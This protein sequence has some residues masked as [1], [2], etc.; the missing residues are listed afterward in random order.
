MVFHVGCAFSLG[1]RRWTG[2]CCVVN[3]NLAIDDHIACYLQLMMLS[4][5]AWQPHGTTQLF[6]LSLK[7]FSLCTNEIK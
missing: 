1:T 7:L 5:D 4:N 3:G 6:F 2:L